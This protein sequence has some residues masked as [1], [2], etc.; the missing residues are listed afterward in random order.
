MICL[1]IESA[2]TSIETEHPGVWNVR[3]IGLFTGARREL[4]AAVGA[5]CH[6]PYKPCGGQGSITFGDSEILDQSSG[7]RGRVSPAAGADH[8]HRYG[9]GTKDISPSD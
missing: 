8:A 9:Q 2:G 5:F 1:S 7:T 6:C 3:A 4:L